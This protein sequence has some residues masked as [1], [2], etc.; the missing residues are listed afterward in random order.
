MADFDETLDDRLPLFFADLLGIHVEWGDQP[1]KFRQGA[2]ATLDILAPTGIGVDD[3]IFEDIDDPGMPGTPRAIRATV[4]GQREFTMQVSVWTPSQKLQRSARK[5]LGR[6]RTRLRL[7]TSLEKM[8][9][10]GIAFIRV[11]ALVDQDF[12]QD[13]RTRSRSLMDIRFGCSVVEV[14][15]EIPYISSARVSSGTTDQPGGPGKGI[16][17]PDGNPSPLQPD[18]TI[19]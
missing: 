5:Y 19:T 7:P 17:N 14:D 4:I 10:L 16:E 3:V 1:Q 18:Q 15:E 11:E 13:G 9:E 8:R 2:Q 12:I 6:L